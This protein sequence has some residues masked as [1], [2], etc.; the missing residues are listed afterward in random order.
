VNVRSRT[1]LAGVLPMSP[2][3]YAPPVARAQGPV[4]HEIVH[5]GPATLEVTVRGQGEPIVFIPSRGRGIEDF[6]DLSNRLVQAGYQTIL[7]QPRGIGGSTGPLD[8]ITYHDLASD[9]AA[10]IQSLAGRPATII[11]H[12]F[13]ARCAWSLLS[14]Y[15]GCNGWAPRQSTL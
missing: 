1:K 12:D 14:A 5:A 3:C 6:D 2:I 13:G 9:I 8:S 10:T 7:P 4:R 15:R 11:G